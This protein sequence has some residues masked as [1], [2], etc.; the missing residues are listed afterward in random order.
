MA[1]SNQITTL[2]AQP[3][4]P[5]GLSGNPE[6]EDG[7]VAVAHDAGVNYFFFYNL[8]FAA[9]RTGLKPLLQAN[10]ETI[11]V[12]TGSESRDPKVLR[13]YLDGVRRRLDV[14][15]IDVFYA[16]Y[17]APGDDIE[18]LLGPDGVFDELHRWKEQGLIRYVGA[19]THN[20][21]LAVDLIESGRIEILMHRYNMA[22]R[23]SE[24]QVL[25]R[26]EAAGI[27][28]VAFTCTRW[29]SLLTGH[30]DWDGPVPSA[31][32]CYRYV[33][34]HPAVHLASTSPATVAQLEE[35]LIALKGAER[36]P[37]RLSLWE[38]Y[39]KLVYGDGTDAFETQW[40]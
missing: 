33:L 17:V 2:E 13:G 9:L 5:L 21:P 8:S 25:P 10:R 28:V 15:V 11:V 23:K 39:G 16:E 4:Q 34:H 26:A 35:N 40:P 29:G 20:R 38:T 36:D 1:K 18:M 12:A 30:R 27:P 19:T 3:V 24:A 22:H 32:D 6:M 31:A 14:E 7:C 37:E